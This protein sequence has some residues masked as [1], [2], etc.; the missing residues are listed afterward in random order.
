MHI[1]TYDAL[2]R[3]TMEILEKG[4]GYPRPQAETTAW[5]LV[6]ADARGVPSHGVARLQFYR[7]NVK[8]GFAFPEAEPEVV[9]ETPVSLVIDGHSGVGAHIAKFAMDACIRKA[10]AT[11]TCSCV[12][13]NSNHYGM[14]GLWAE[15][16]AQEKCL[17]MAMTN[18]RKCCIVTFG[19]ERLLGTNPIAV[20]V[21]G[22]GEEI[23]LLDMATPVVAHGKVEVY[24]RRKKPMPLGWAVDE[25][26]K[27]TDD[28][29]HLEELFKE[30]S[31]WGGHL[32]LGGEGET[33]GGHKGYGLGLMVDL[34]CSA[35]SLGRWSPQT[36][37]NP[38]TGSGITHYFAVTS[39]D[40]YGDAEGIRRE[41][42]RI[43]Q[44]VRSSA[45]A[46]GQERIYIHGEKESESRQRSLKE[47]ISLDEATWKIL[48]EYAR[49]FGVTPLAE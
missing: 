9:H 49:E 44:E 34:F 24:D 11:G 10:Y 8:G 12:V 4:L 27:T 46:E 36:F 23:F 15:R 30:E 16:A 18:T 21:P 19:K 37:Q 39:L 32:F 6:E 47:G 29:S 42:S 5:V 25:T 1:V 2:F 26:G 31:P 41:V 17:G 3:H 45:K 48:G 22:Q 14:A 7:Q 33:L 43:L 13:R 35:F 38:G 40:V 28:A 20:A